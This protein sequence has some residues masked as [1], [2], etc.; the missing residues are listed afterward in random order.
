MSINICMIYCLF[1]CCILLLQLILFWDFP[2][3]F[4]R[5]SGIL[6]N[7]VVIYGWRLV[8][9]LIILPFWEHLR[10]LLFEFEEVWSFV[11]FILPTFLHHLEKW[12][13][14][15]PRLG[16]AFILFQPVRQ[17]LTSN[18]RVWC[19]SNC[20]YLPKDNAIRPNITS[21]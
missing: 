15:I 9:N 5:K 20:K 21:L 7:I 19:F 6:I 14:T 1:H 3:W 12:I 8:V 4:D 16:I 11:W 2:H 13:V 10:Q 17:V 18:I